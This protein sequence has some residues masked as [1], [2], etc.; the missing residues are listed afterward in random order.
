MS[1]KVKGAVERE[2]QMSNQAD[3]KENTER[4]EKIKR[5]RELKSMMAYFILKIC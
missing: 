2:K 4:K 5:K 3:G 1:R